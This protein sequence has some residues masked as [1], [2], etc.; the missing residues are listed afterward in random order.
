MNGLPNNMYRYGATSIDLRRLMPL[1]IT[2]C[3]IPFPCEPLEQSFFT[4]LP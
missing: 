3:Q 1:L 2:V 4:A